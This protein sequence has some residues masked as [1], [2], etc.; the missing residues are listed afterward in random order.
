MADPTPAEII[1]KNLEKAVDYSKESGQCLKLLQAIAN[2]E[3]CAVMAFIAPYAAVR[4]SP[5][6][7]RSA[8]IGLSEEFGIIRTIDQLK[9]SGTNRPRVEK[10]YLMINSP[11]GY[12][13]S[14]YKIA[15]ALRTTFKE[16]K[17][18]VPHV[19]ASGGTLMALIGNAIVM[20]KM[21]NLTPIDVQ[22]VYKNQSV[23]AYSMTTA[24]SR[25]TNFFQTT[26]EDEAPY[27]WKAM[28]DKLDP[29][30]LEHWGG[31]LTEMISYAQE[32]LKLADYK[33]DII[34]KITDALV[35]PTGTHEFVIDI[36]R[37]S[38]L[39]IKL[40]SSA[41]E[42]QDLQVM[43]AWLSEYMLKAADKHIIRFVLPEVRHGNEKS[44]KARVKA[45][46]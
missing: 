34:R 28:T 42:T 21:S 5:T 9:G 1:K 31:S 29:V 35:L 16:I 6:E 37:A 33:P 20:G 39:E 14:S 17:V 8:S 13:H 22:V 30:L 11:G 40:S 26:T 12:V 3:K 2:R 25:L 7:A 44:K 15:K 36:D 19:A 27:P 4:V 32:L 10:L 45:A 38:R 43:E 24:F 41:Q 18:F 46:K 23:S